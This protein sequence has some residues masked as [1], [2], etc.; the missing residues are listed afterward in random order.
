MRAWGRGLPTT[1]DTQKV[2]KVFWISG[3]GPTTCAVHVD[4]DAYIPWAVDDFRL[5]DVAAAG[6]QVLAQC[7]MARNKI[8]L[9]YP[10]G[11]DG[12]VYAKVR[13]KFHQIDC[14]HCKD[15]CTNI[16]KVKNYSNRATN[17]DNDCVDCE[18]RFAFRVGI[19][20]PIQ[21]ADI[22]NPRYD[23]HSA[24]RDN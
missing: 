20:Q 1:A 2:P 23:G 12:H 24:P 15:N 21:R 14:T 13:N 10:A 11:L 6:E 9:E 16:L 5:S 7:L 3:R 19:V 8:G 17:T 22:C 4:V 18:D